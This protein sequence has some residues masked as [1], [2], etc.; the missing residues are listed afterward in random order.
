MTLKNKIWWW[1]GLLVAFVLTIV[2]L[3]IW[4]SSQP[5]S[6]AMSD[7]DVDTPVSLGKTIVPSE[8]PAT[9]GADWPLP[10]KKLHKVLTE[11]E[12]RPEASESLEEQMVDLN[13]EIERINEQIGKIDSPPTDIP[14]SDDSDIPARL[15]AI[16]AHLEAQQK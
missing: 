7:S 12:F 8:V 6:V 15:E 4:Q 5:P 1:V 10:A 2:G 3:G 14:S 13:Q 16:K 9:P 11:A